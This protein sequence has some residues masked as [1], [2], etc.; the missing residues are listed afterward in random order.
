M[1]EGQVL[2][3]SVPYQVSGC[4]LT[5]VVC[6]YSNRYNV[7]LEEGMV[8]ATDVPILPGT[9]LVITLTYHNPEGV[10]E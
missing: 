9:N 8:I 2:Y 4:H 7:T 1:E 6:G 3:R 5:G 10:P